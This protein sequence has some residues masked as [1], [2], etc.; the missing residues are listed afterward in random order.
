MKLLIAFWLLL[1]PTATAQTIWT[2]KA[3]GGT[4]GL[5]ALQDAV[6]AANQDI[7]SPRPIII[8]IE[9]NQSA[10]GTSGVGLVIPGNYDMAIAN[11][12]NN[13]SGLI[14]ITVTAPHYWLT[15]DTAV[16][17][18]VG[19]VPAANG[20][21]VITKVDATTVDLQG[22][23][24][25]GTFTSGGVV[26]RLQRGDCGQNPIIVRGSG[27]S[28]GTL[29]ANTRVGNLGG[30]AD[31]SLARVGTSLTFYPS[32]TIG[33]RAACWEFHGLEFPR[34]AGN[35]PNVPIVLFGDVTTLY[36]GAKITEPRDEAHDITFR[37]V[38]IHGNINEDGPVLG[39]NASAHRIRF[40]DSSI[41]QVKTYNGESKALL[42][43]VSQG[44]WIFRNN[45]IHSS[46]IGTLFGGA[47][48]SVR[49]QYPEG[50]LYYGNYYTKSPSWRSLW[51][52]FNPT[53]P[54]FSDA[55]GG[56]YWQNTMA[57]TY[58]HCVGGAWQTITAVEY[59]AWWLNAFPSYDIQKNNWEH[60]TGRRVEND[61]LLCRNGWLPASQ[62]QY[63]TCMLLNL[64]DGGDY[65]SEIASNNGRGSPWGLGLQLRHIYI[66]NVKADRQCYL[67]SNGQTLG[68]TYHQRY[69]IRASNI[70]TTNLGEATNCFDHEGDV[71]PQIGQG[72]MAVGFQMGLNERM[73]FHNNTALFN[74]TTFTSSRAISIDNNPANQTAFFDNV[75]TYAAKGAL[76]T[77]VWGSNSSEAII[78]GWK[79]TRELAQNWF[80]DDRSQNFVNVNFNTATTEGTAPCR[81][82]FQVA[83]FA[84]MNFVNYPT[85]LRLTASSPGNMAGLNGRQIGADMDEHDA[86][87]EGV[88]AG[89]HNKYFDFRIKPVDVTGST[90]ATLRY[91]AYDQNACTVL[92]SPKPDFSSPVY[93][94][95][96]GTGDT[97]REVNLTS[98][99]AGRT[100]YYTKIT[101][102]TRKRETIFHMQSL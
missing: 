3:S 54:C 79:Q 98:L 4:Y 86:S 64:V 27:V 11:A 8:D 9:K 33:H 67:L 34:Q 32:L 66:R 19:G 49:N 18:K 93:N 55:S 2:V 76:E 80:I 65:Y 94:T 69:N 100:R 68:P 7:T 50:V 39:V 95:T 70:V 87:L 1:A 6:N 48:P 91:S 12:A 101:C 82:C 28:D 53:N 57:T 72:A 84:A 102:G 17:F 30:T 99:A 44:D 51:G 89:L 47:I 61:G 97:E 52:P 96:S 81:G 62:S 60:K 43:V 35:P 40:Y 90:T 36:G 25:S 10:T 46:Y 13:G 22:S 23:A 26:Y 14:R 58:W 38:Y 21:W 5:G 63:G 71:D 92:V 31:A 88:E 83:N 45:M 74:N 56:E 24:F 77:K 59:N 41:T 20:A 73:V 37:Q 85:N 16:V 15:G 29:P 75:M 42:S 78:A